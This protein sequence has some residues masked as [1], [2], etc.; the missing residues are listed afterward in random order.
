MTIWLELSKHKMCSLLHVA[1][2]IFTLFLLEVGAKSRTY[3]FQNGK[4]TY[5]EA[6]SNCKDKGMQ[7]ATAQSLDDYNELGRLL[8]QPQYKDQD[9]WATDQD[10]DRNIAWTFTFNEAEM[11]LISQEGDWAKT[12]CMLVRSFFHAGTAGTDWNDDLCGQ[13]HGYICDRL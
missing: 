9:F 2:L 13:T 3:E 6:W 4:V 7:L 5:E 10:I 12:R 1:I 11:T 8:N